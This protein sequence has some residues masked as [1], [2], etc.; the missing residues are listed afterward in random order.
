MSV[1]DYRYVNVK[2]EA[3]KS[4]Q[5]GKVRYLVT[6]THDDFTTLSEMPDEGYSEATA[7]AWR[8]NEWHFVVVKVTPE[9]NGVDI[10]LP[11]TS[12][13]IEWGSSP[14]WEQDADMDY[15]CKNFVPDLISEVQTELIQFRDALVNMDLSDN[16]S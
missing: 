16:A 11:Q 3:E 4:I 1:I 5:A 7:K 12:G 2:G 10:D 9:V 6:V 13:G 14:D 8:D 15:I